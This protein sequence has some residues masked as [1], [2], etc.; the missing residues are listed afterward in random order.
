MLTVSA[1]EGQQP[2]G[3][4]L[5]AGAFAARV[6]RCWA[7]A[8]RDVLLVDADA[9]GGGLAGRIGGACRLALDPARRGLPTLIASR[10]SLSFE[11]VA[12]HCW[13]LPTGDDGSVRLLGAPAHP[14]GARLSA[15]W[16]AERSTQLRALGSCWAVAVSMPGPPVDA[17]ETL[18]AAA[19]RSVVLTGAAGTAPPGGMRAVLSA[20]WLR[21]GPDPVTLLLD[22]GNDERGG[23]GEITA[24]AERRVLGWVGP[25][26]E[27]AL[28][29]G[30]VGRRDR[31]P[32]AA[33]DAVAAHLWEPSGSASALVTGAD[34]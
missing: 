14:Q 23:D 13:Q 34:R 6:A 8:G 20:F 25:V 32:L 31:S 11:N 2:D 3:P 27:A 4:G 21:S 16:L 29:G 28:L 17:Y 9:H 5:D 26:R 19:T 15:A 7:Q 1:A 22:D 24:A 33:V 12:R 10:A 18:G 30:R